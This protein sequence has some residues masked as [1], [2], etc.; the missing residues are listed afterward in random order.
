MPEGPEVETI[1][2][3]LQ[4]I[5]GADVCYVDST[6]MKGLLKN[7]DE[8]TMVRN[9]TMMSIERVER[10]GKWILFTLV[11]PNP[12]EPRY[13]FLSHLGMFGHW[14]ISWNEVAPSVT[15]R[16]LTLRLKTQKGAALL[17]Y[18]DMRSWGRLYTFTLVEAF[19]FLRGRVGV[20]ATLVTPSQLSYF[21]RRDV[22][23]IAEILLD[24]SKV[25]GI[26]NI[27]RSEILLRSCIAPDRPGTD[28][29]NDEVQV[30]W[31][32][33]RR[34]MSEAIQLR[35]SSIRDYRDTNGERGEFHNYLKAYGR[36]GQNCKNCM[37]AD[38]MQRNPWPVIAAT[39]VIDGRTVF[40]CPTCQL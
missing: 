28:I 20:D 24:Q 26:G 13:A 22:R 2:R 38:P 19:N 1:V 7:A 23:P 39:K 3:G 31:L 16:R 25:A 37:L 35:G 15:H 11:S 32:N 10:H 6:D 12:T 36:E 14:L 33:T 40:Y 30:I 18:S 34:V 21:L 17:T 27:Y 5:V 9:L 8:A 29:T 4:S